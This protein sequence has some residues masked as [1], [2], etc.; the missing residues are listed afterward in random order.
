MV[1]DKA[2]IIYS[3]KKSVNELEQAISDSIDNNNQNYKE[4][5]NRLGIVLLWIGSCLDRLTSIGVTYCENEANYVLAF[6]GAY[7]AQ[8]HSILVAGFQHYKEG[9]IS[10]PIHF[11]LSIPSSNYYFN[12][13]DENI[14][15]RKYQIKIYNK[16]LANKPIIPEI[17]KMQQM[18]I[19]KFEDL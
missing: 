1:A 8:K 19:T 12:R 2:E 11:P 18:I 3:L 10:F 9:G 6:R 14:I 5:Y 13:L 7:N 4:I 15:D 16:I 17:K